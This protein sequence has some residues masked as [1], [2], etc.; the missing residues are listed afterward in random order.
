LLANRA[1]LKL[2]GMASD[3]KVYHNTFTFHPSYT[4]VVAAFD[5]ANYNWSAIS[6][7][8]GGQP[9]PDPWRIRGQHF[10][11]N[12]ASYGGGSDPI[13]GGLMS[14]FGGNTNGVCVLRN[15]GY[16]NPPELLF[17]GAWTD[18]GGKTLQTLNSS[19]DQACEAENRNTW[20]TGTVW[21]A[22]L[23][24]TFVD[25]AAGNF[26]IKPGSVA[27]GSATDGG[28]MGA[29]VQAV[30]TATAEAKLG[31]RRNPWFDMLIRHI[32][33]APTG[34]VIDLVKP[35][36]AECTIVVA[37][38]RAWV[39]AGTVA[40]ETNGRRVLATVTGLNPATEYFVKAE[41]GSEA[42]LREASF[43]TAGE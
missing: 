13:R 16:Y 23:G 7:W 30:E 34:A 3:V 19:E 17:R 35:T 20:E 42:Y 15:M 33:P 32:A 27:K 9:H 8:N 22:T 31:S 1:F 2:V 10:R 4:E 29:D 43:M 40:Q 6:Q 38:N 14:S 37:A 5:Y 18:I 11:D 12:V 26:R 41:C 39:P 25:P 36:V 21:D 24:D 28:D